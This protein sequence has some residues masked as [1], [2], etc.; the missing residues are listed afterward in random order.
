MDDVLVD[1]MRG[2][3]STWT[4]IR[5]NLRHVPEEM[6][7]PQETPDPDDDPTREWR[8][9]RE[10]VGDRRCLNGELSGRRENLCQLLRRNDFELRI[11]AV[12]RPLV[13]SPPPKLRRVTEAPALHVIVC[14]LDDQL[15][16][17]RLPRQILA[18]APAALAA[19]HA[20]CRLHRG[21]P[22]SAQCLPR[23]IRERVLAIRR[24]EFHQLPPLLV[25]EARAHADVLEL[26]GIIE[27]AEQQRADRGRSPFLCQRKPATTQSQSR[28][29]LTLSITRLFGS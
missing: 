15:G 17:Q 22:A 27:E 18:L 4:R 1:S 3:S 16:P 29:C 8:N 11:G 9:A 21:L 24:E 20:L 7:P 10:E 14:D 6:R 13:G 12:A 19:R 5:V 26:A 2:R 28:S 25:G 23:V